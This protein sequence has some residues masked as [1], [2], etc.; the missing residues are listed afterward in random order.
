M[1]KRQEERGTV[2]VAADICLAQEVR[3][4]WDRGRVVLESQGLPEPKE[5]IEGYKEEYD[6]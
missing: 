1:S 5:L 4:N 6:S 2:H 3:D